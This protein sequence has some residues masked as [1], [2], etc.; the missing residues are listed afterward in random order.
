MG[1]KKLKAQIKLAIQG[2]PVV[3]ILVL[4]TLAGKLHCCLDTIN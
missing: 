3:I 2:H 1:N 4:R